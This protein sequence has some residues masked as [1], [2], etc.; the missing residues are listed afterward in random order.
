MKRTSCSSI[1]SPLT[2]YDPLLTGT[3]QLD[4]NNTEST[5]VLSPAPGGIVAQNTYTASAGL[6]Y[7]M[8]PFLSAALNASYAERVGNHIITPQDIVTVSLNYRPY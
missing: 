3:A 5:S 2:S 8:T 1:G 6:I 7:S 4:K